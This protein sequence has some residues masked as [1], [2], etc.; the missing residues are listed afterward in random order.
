MAPLG[1][2]VVI[3]IISDTDMSDAGLYLPEGAKQAMAESLLG[4]VLEVASA[5][6]S[7]SRE[8]ENISGVPLGAKVLVK[9]GSGVK[10]PWDETL[11]IVETAEVLALVTE[12]EIT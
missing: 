10:V 1:M 2:R 7:D 9:K 11:R 4:E 3:K 6:D 8:E 12:I 5:I